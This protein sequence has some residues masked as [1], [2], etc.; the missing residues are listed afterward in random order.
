MARPKKIGLDYFPHDVD[1]SN[2]EKI[3]AMEILH[4]HK[5]YAFVFKMYE[6][7]YRAG[8]R[9]RV[10]DSETRQ[11]LVRNMG[12][13]DENDLDALIESGINRE[14]FD[15]KSWVNDRVLTSGGILKRVHAV[16]NKRVRSRGV[17]EAETP[18]E[19]QQKPVSNASIRGES[20]V[21]ESKVKEEENATRSDHRF[22]SFSGAFCSY[23][24]DEIGVKYD[25]QAKDGV[26]LAAFLKRN[27]DCDIEQF[28]EAVE[29]C[30]K[31]RFHRNHFSLVYICSNFAKL[32]AGA[33]ANTQHA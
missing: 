25:F 30:H 2:D 22:S 18:P 6:R 16:E 9:F 3:Q 20:K 26:Q 17:S 12:L 13:N 14:L 21:K 11:I 33:N 24:Q 8:G 10:S 7:I 29:W 1:A 15:R 32:M 19:T 4:G 28:G 5:G 31:D 23:Y 27:P